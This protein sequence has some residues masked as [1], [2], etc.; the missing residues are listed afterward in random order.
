MIGHRRLGA[1]RNQVR[2]APIRARFL[3]LRR[4]ARRLYAEGGKGLSNGAGLGA[5]M[6]LWGAG[7]TRLGRDVVVASR[8]L[9]KRPIWVLTVVSILALGIGANVAIFSGFDAWVLRPL[10][11]PEPDRLVNVAENHPASGSFWLGVS[12]SNLADWEVAQ[13]SFE[14]LGAFTRHTYN[15]NDPAN[16]VR[17]DGARISASLFPTLGKTP[18]RG[19]GIT[20][21]EDAPGRPA[22]VALISHRLWQTRFEGEPAIVGRTIRLDGQ[23][24]EIV[25]VM[26]PGFH[27]PEYADIWTPLGADSAGDRSERSL[28]V[29]GRLRTGVSVAIA[30][31]ELA[32]IASRIATAHP[33]AD[34]GYGADLRPLRDYFVPDVIDTAVMA[35][36][37]ASL[38][39]LLVICANVAS[40][41][42]A[43][44]N[45]R[46]RETAIR[47]AM[48]ASRGH[49]AWLGIVE[50]LLLAL[51]AGLLGTLLGVAW[52][53]HMVGW[54]P[55]EPPYLFTMTLNLRVGIY[56]LLASAASGIVCGL[57]PLLG[58][59]DRVLEALKDGRAVTGEGR[60]ARW[61][62][63]VLVVGELALS[64]A[65]V[66]AALLTIRSFVALREVDRGYRTQGV[67]EATLS[68]A[69][70]DS[71]EARIGQARRL[72]SALQQIPAATSVG[73]TSALPVSPWYVRWELVPFGQGDSPDKSVAATAHAIAGDYRRALG[74]PL[75]AGRDF[76]ENEVWDHG[77]ADVALVS[78]GLARQLWGAADPLGRRLRAREGDRGSWLTVVGVVGNVDYGRD[79][80]T[81]GAFPDVQIYLPY[82]RLPMA[83][84]SAVVSAGSA[85]GAL[86]P[87]V[88]SAIQ[89]G[90]PGVPFSEILPLEQ[91]ILR[92]RWASG[93]F[94][95]LLGVY[96]F[97]AIIIAAV[98]LYG[99]MAE[100]TSRR[101]RELGVR[102]ALGARRRSIVQLIAGE[103]LRM[104]IVGVG[105][106]L[107]LTLAVSRLG[108]AMF[109]LV[110]ASD[111]TV[112][113]TVAGALLMVSLV[114]AAL[115]AWRAS[116]LD[117]AE[118]LRA[119]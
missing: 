25:G 21:A 107:A 69:E 9:L 63:R 116:G 8:Q 111:P 17:L 113:A 49:L 119:E 43:R 82:G 55:V 118:I 77:G 19:R 23:L 101:T 34:E 92:Q 87:D 93:F 78:A 36:L 33:D 44:A 86:V 40:L 91:A 57:A 83:S 1:L 54:V 51:P 65:L 28:S 22:A 94:S 3:P 12:A 106:G 100:T 60:T 117:A 20:T 95:R 110:D 56:T 85:A 99:L 50:G 59:A 29:V 114:A 7:M 109:P 52:Q 2:N 26:E 5:P 105:L 31:Q 58:G 115:P 47:A 35:A 79:M 37:C 68:F 45:G 104:G 10:D 84:L 30:R 13:R 112:F 102:L 96:A 70:R 18:E 66:A 75:V 38:C 74:I 76:S 48:G 15:V 97:A 80:V 62:R 14:S 88:R 71:P 16:P 6:N 81:F 108:A 46:R 11:F 53:R 98:G 27:F 24:R 42:L 72:L 103:A 90:V 39:V 67:E 64:T 4:L 41:M 89:R 61:G 73:L 32:A